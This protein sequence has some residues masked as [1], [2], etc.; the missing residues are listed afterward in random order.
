[1]SRLILVPLSLL[2][3]LVL[4]AAILIPLFLGQDKVLQLAA[5]AV[6]TQTGATLTIEG[7]AKLSVF[8][9]PGIALSDAAIT[10]PDKQQADLRG[11][12]LQI[13]TLQ[14]GVQLLPLLLIKL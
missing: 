7:D 8:P 13:G 11:G 9:A 12:T 3:L 4:A 6:H 5:E 14:I 10:L 2:L 1:M